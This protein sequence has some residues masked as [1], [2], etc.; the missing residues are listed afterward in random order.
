MHTMSYKNIKAG[1]TSSLCS[2][3]QRHSPLNSV[4]REGC[5]L[6][7][8][9][10]M[11]NLYTLPQSTDYKT[12]DHCHRWKCIM[13]PRIMGGSNYVSLKMFNCVAWAPPRDDRWGRHGCD[14]VSPVLEL[15]PRPLPC[16]VNHLAGVRCWL[17]QNRRSAWPLWTPKLQQ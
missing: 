6:V 12:K 3:V 15:R 7:T 5:Y 11:S 10:L 17:R 1:L 8:A 14:L 13:K 16:W 2:D 4:G 9:L